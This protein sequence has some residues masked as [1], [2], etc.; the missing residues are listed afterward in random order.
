LL[1]N[2]LV[3][4]SSLSGLM[5]H[6]GIPRV[7]NTTPMR[8]FA[9]IGDVPLLVPKQFRPQYSR[10]TLAS[11]HNA[12]VPCQKHPLTLNNDL[13]LEERCPA[14][15]RS[16]PADGSEARRWSAFLTS[17]SGFVSFD[18]MRL[19]RSARQPFRPWILSCQASANYQRFLRTGISRNGFCASKCLH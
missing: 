13:Y 19:N 3:Q 12:R 9:I 18:R 2:A 6:T 16:R 15:R 1:C 10:L 8:Q 14:S 4:L 5:A 11:F 7:A 17:I